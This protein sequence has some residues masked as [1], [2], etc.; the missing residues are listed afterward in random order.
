MRW[1]GETW[2]APVNESTEEATIPIGEACERCEVEIKE[3]DRGFLIPGFV[4]DSKTVRE[5]PYH[6]RCF[7]AGV[8]GDAMADDIM[9]EVSTMDELRKRS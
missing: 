5:F 2:D 1:F 4:D 6:L 9:D 8:I 7:M 3:G